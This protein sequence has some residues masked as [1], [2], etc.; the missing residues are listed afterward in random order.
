MKIGPIDIERPLL[1][2]PMEGV[3]DQPF[4][5]ICKNL[6]ADIV[7]TEFVNA[8]GL[9]RK[10]SKTYKKMEFLEE[11]RPFGI[12]IYGGNPDSM[13]NAARMAEG[14]HPDLIDI[15]CGCWV[16]NVT[17]NGAGS[18][19]LRDLSRMET[20]IRNVV[21]ATGLPV[22]VKTRLGWDA[23]NIRIVDVAKMVEES[24]AA[25]LTIHCR[26]RTQAH[27][28]EPDFSWIAKVKEAV[29]IPIIA[30]GSLTTPEQIAD[31]F[32]STGC[33]G[34]M[35]GRAAID[36]P[37]LFKQTRQYLETG[38]CNLQPSI[39]ERFNILLQHLRLSLQMKGEKRGIFEFRKHYSGYLKGYPN[40]SKIR[41]ELMSELAYEPIEKILRTYEDFLL[42]S[43][44]EIGNAAVLQ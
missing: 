14:L 21:Q 25:A 19:L 11:E 17:N 6:G 18:D 26:T 22:T 23:E 9:V 3:T 34:V 8:E 28:G 42:K 43:E 38:S 16:K 1:L 40:A 4:R 36:N 30:N 12:Q 33:D 39:Q 29:A 15:N 5:L 37:W 41:S 7:Y 35:I 31:I 24:G 2:A 27:K 20:I 13:Q 32:E 10:S 44:L